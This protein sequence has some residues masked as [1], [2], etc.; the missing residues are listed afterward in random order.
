M[1]LIVRVGGIPWPKTGA[2][3]Y[4]AHLGLLDKGR[5]SQRVC[6]LM[7]EWTFYTA[8]ISGVCFKVRGLERGLVPKAT[9]SPLET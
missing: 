5:A 3:H 4:H 2:T 1:T 8:I 6:C 7:G 9:L